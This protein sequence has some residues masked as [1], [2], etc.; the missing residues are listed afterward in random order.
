MSAARERA[1]SKPRPE[2]LPPVPA[3]QLD[4]AAAQ[5]EQ[6]TAAANDDSPLVKLTSV[7]AADAEPAIADQEDSENQDQEDSEWQRL[8]AVVEERDQAESERKMRAMREIRRLRGNC[9]STKNGR[10]SPAPP[11]RRLAAGTMPPPIKGAPK[12]L[13]IVI[14]PDPA[15]APAAP[16]SEPSP[17]SSL[18]RI[19]QRLTRN[20]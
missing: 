12:K 1:D 19:T 6:G 15:K 3:P 10:P 11:K 9:G 16:Q 8:R 20:N 14:A 17:A 18:P 5:V 2:S 4:V 13:A 7:P